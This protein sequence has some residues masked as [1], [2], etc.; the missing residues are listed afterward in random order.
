[1]SPIDYSRYPE[2]WKELRAAVLMRADNRCEECGVSNGAVGARDNTG[3]WWNEDRIH[4]LNS[5]DGELLFPDG[6]P[7][8]TKIVLTVH[9]R[10]QDLANNAPENLVV[11]CQR[12]HLRRDTKMHARHARATRARKR[13]QAFLFPDAA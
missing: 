13:G 5:D 11:L 1:M 6:F 3:E 7:E 2:N 9:H 4:N 12:C 10:D 8:M